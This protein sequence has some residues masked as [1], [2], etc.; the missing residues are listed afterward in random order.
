MIY[1]TQEEYK[2]I[3]LDTLKLSTKLSLEVNG[4]NYDIRSYV[5]KMILNTKIYEFDKTINFV[6]SSSQI[7]FYEVVNQT[8][9][10]AILTSN[11]CNE[12]IGILNFASAIKAGGG[13][14][15]GRNAQEEDIMRK[16]T[17][18]PS[19]VIQDKFYKIHNKGNPFYSNTIIYSPNVL[20]I[21]DD[22]YNLIVPKEINVITSA[23]INLSEI[24]KNSYLVNI[25][26]QM[27]SMGNFDL[28]EEVMLQ[29]IERILQVAIDNNIECLILGAFGCGVFGHDAKK[30][31]N[32]FYFLLKNKGYEIY[33]K[34]IIFA[35]LDNSPMK[36][37]YNAFYNP[38]K[39]NTLN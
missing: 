12:K 1:L 13:W 33:F 27:N 23:A 17:L 30:V 7:P 34:K 2:N 24:N 31:A 28:V 29:R 32:W 26:N 6:S 35:V 38:F 3:A 14:L 9:I 11:I 4:L 5:N 21:K 22:D 16:T 39:N 37:N 8:T 15:N 20:V 19:L 25:I 36:I 18:F 10:N